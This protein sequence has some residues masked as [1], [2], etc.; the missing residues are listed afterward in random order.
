[1]KHHSNKQRNNQD[2]QLLALAAARCEGRTW[3]LLTSDTVKDT[4]GLSDLQTARLF[5]RLLREQRIQR[6]QRGLYLIPAVPPPSKRWV[7]SP[8]EALWA[9]M[10]W[11]KATWQITGYAAF[12]RHGFSTQIVQRMT[13]LNDTLSG[14]QE[15]GGSRFV[16]VKLPSQKL[17]FTQKYSLTG[18]I[19]I[20]FSSR[21]RSLF[22]A[23]AEA[24]RFAVLPEAYGWFTSLKKNPDDVLVLKKICLAI[25]NRQTVARIGF[26]LESLGFD[27]S[28]LLPKIGTAGT[29]VPLVPMTQ[30]ERRGT[31]NKRW[32]IIEN[33][34]LAKIF[35]SQEVPD[36]DE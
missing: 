25:G 26:V 22:D 36:E 3:A 15:V 28:E 9:Y 6:L 4:L 19:E 33:V 16:F 29:L 8:Y 11:L 27:A 1:M 5:T 18:G 12:T 7:P 24:K 2:Y 35:S 20:V 14:E 32:R 23:V 34:S 10:N 31:A 17:G 13:V 21:Q 30:N